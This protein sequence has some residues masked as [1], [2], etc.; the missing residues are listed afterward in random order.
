MVRRGGGGSR[1]GEDG[2]VM[3]GKGI[4]GG[5]EGK[6]AHFYYCYNPEIIHGIKHVR[7]VD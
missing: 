3:K 5:Q 7:F 4:G 6:R 2:E 1:A